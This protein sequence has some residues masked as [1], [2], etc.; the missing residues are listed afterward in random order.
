MSRKVFISGSI[1]IKKLPGEVCRSIDRIMEQGMGILV[2]DAR[3]IDSLVQGYCVSKNYFDVTVYTISHPPRNLASE[4]FGV[5]KIDAPDSL[6]NK[7]KRQALKDRAMTEESD[8]S[9][10]V[11]DGKSKGSYAN[12]ARALEQ[13]KKVKV[14]MVPEER[15]LE[16]AELSGIFEG[17]GC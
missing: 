11:W 17:T 15:F 6:K 3:G 10:V 2:G 5:R 8:F 4:K 9:L 16:P 13:G 12:I 1:S 14:Y 7:R